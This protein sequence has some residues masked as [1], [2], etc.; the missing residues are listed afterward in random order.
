MP[1]ILKARFTTYKE[2]KEYFVC[3]CSFLNVSSFFLSEHVSQR[4]KTFSINNRMCCEMLA[5]LCL[6]ALLQ[7]V[8]SLWSFS[9]VINHPAT[10]SHLMQMNFT[11]S[12]IFN[13]PF[14]VWTLSYLIPKTCITNFMQNQDKNQ[15][16][17][18]FL[19][20]LYCIFLVQCYLKETNEVS[21][22]ATNSHKWP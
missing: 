7:N 4:R 10:L 11:F 14:S 19:T 20:I 22:K 17:N 15:Y 1:S 6:T 9:S 3:V 5:L 16:W 13:R 18:I 2:C 21:V 12:H 8:H